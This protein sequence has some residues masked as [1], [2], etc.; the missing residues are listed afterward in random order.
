M[1]QYLVLISMVMLGIYIFN[2]I[3]GNGPDSI[4]TSL[5]YIWEQ[6]IAVRT[7]TP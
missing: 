6:G 2:M 5:E 7:Y 1:K 4:H 3:A